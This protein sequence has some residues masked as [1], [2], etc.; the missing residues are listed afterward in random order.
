VAKVSSVVDVVV[1]VEEEEEDDDDDDERQREEARVERQRVG[2]RL[3]KVIMFEMKTPGHLRISGPFDPA[4][5]DGD[6]NHHLHV[7]Q[8]PW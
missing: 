5:L 2:E 3:R 4:I 6:V 7:V 1:V 8:G